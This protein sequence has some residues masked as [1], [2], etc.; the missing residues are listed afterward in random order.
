MFLPRRTVSTLEYHS[1][2][3]YH[4][5]APTPT[6]VS[7][8]A[9][10]VSEMNVSFRLS[11]DNYSQLFNSENYVKGNTLISME[12]VTLLSKRLHLVPNGAEA[13]LNNI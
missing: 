4:F 12:S 7:F 3:T 5:N 9:W 10:E 8:H 1:R 13:R 11:T 6:P 2:H